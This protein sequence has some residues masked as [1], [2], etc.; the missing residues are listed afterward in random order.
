MAVNK[1]NGNL[2]ASFPVEETD[3][4]MLMTNAGKLIRCPVHDIRIAGRNTQGV[5]I[6]RTDKSETVISAICIPG[7]AEDESE[8]DIE[9]EAGSQ[10]E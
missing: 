5:T 2:I 8:A 1:R 10:D 3:Q 9:G 4:I 7:G 6:F